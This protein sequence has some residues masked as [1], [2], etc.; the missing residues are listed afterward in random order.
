MSVFDVIIRDRFNP[1]A[2]GKVSVLWHA[3]IAQ[4]PK[5][6]TRIS[7]HI[8]DFNSAVYPAPV[9]KFCDLRNFKPNILSRFFGDKPAQKISLRAAANDAAAPKKREKRNIFQPYKF[10]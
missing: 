10:G 7:S 6:K 9:S 3:D 2:A 4:A 1:Q 8:V 5:N